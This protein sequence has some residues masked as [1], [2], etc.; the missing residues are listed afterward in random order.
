MTR[1]RDNGTLRQ[2]PYDVIWSDRIDFSELG[3]FWKEGAVEVMLRAIWYG[4]DDLHVGLFSIV[5]VDSADD[6]LERSIT[7]LLEPCI[8][9]HLSGNEPFFLQHA[10]YEMATRKP[11]PAQPP[12]Y[13]MAFVF[14]QNRRIMWPLE[15]K[16]LRNDR[17]V[18]SYVREI[19]DN[20]LTGRYAPFVDGGAMLGYLLNG[21]PRNVIQELSQRLGC[22]LK[23]F[24]ELSSARHRVSDHVRKLSGEGFSSGRFQCHHLVLVIY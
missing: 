7:Q 2:T 19:R 12:Q 3:K 18:A 24:G 23:E 6:E 9:Q 11:A 1:R 17:A 15:A 20:F 22:K 8:Q 14:R 13:D 5:N 16:V 21:S 4:F 10:P